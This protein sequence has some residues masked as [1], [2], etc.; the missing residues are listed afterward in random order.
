M[1]DLE[2]LGFASEVELRTVVG[3]NGK[4][5]EWV[6]DSEVQ[7]KIGMVDVL[8]VEAGTKAF[9]E[10]FVEHHDWGEIADAS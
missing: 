3:W 5:E 9:R 7:G 8:A 2:Q 6:Q 1:D 4:E 10:A